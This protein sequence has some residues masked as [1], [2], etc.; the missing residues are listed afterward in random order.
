MATTAFSELGHDMIYLIS[1]FLTGLGVGVA[2]DLL[3]TRTSINKYERRL[4]VLEH[5]HWG[6]VALMLTRVLQVYIRL[7]LALAGL[8]SIFILLEIVQDHPFA[9]RSDHQISSTGT[10]VLLICILCLIWITL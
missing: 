6:L 2:I 10:G 8:A 7:T 3:W 1:S 9:F 5:Y 4:E